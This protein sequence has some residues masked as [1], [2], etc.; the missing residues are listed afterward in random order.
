MLKPLPIS[1]SYET[2]EAKVPRVSRKLRTTA[3]CRYRGN[4]WL[5]RVEVAR[6]FV[7]KISSSHRALNRLRVSGSDQRR[8]VKVVR[9]EPFFLR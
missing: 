4:R 1:K 2:A 7:V 6:A 5:T 8:R 9:C 3:Q